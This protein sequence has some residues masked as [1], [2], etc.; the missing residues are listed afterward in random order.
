MV[1]VWHFDDTYPLW[2]GSYSWYNNSVPG[3]GRI[4]WELCATLLSVP[5]WGR[6]G[7]REGERRMPLML[8]A[9]LLARRHRRRGP[10][11][12]NSVHVT[13]PREQDILQRTIILYGVYPL[14]CNIE[15]ACPDHTNILAYC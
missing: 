5:R 13:C 7:A 11:L 15:S 14:L 3:R 12:S 10:R 6:T 9:L 8:A 4:N 1:K 2:A